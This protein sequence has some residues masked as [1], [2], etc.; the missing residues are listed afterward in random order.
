M[1]VN[2]QH[3]LEETIGP[4]PLNRI[5]LCSADVSPDSQRKA[6][7]PAGFF[8]SGGKWIGALRNTAESIG[9]RFVVLTTAYGLVD[10]DDLI[11]PYD[12]HIDH[13]KEE[14]NSIW[15]QTIP[16]SLGHVRFDL[17]VFYSGGCPIDPYVAFL[18][19]ILTNLGISL[20]T[21]GKP[22]M[23]DIDKTKVLV[24]LLTNGTSYKKIASELKCP[25]RLKFYSA[26]ARS[27][28]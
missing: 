23:N 1:T 28:G 22:N 20:L 25:D 5:V 14:V 6:P 12:V 11:K 24:K 10:P 21:F 26:P 4:Y 15:N 19:P 2:N 8:F 18:K 17:M 7:F 3:G 9:C 16:P 13:F 27:K